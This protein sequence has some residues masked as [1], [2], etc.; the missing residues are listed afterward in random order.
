MGD[1]KRS[2]HIRCL[3]HS[4]L[5][6]FTWSYI[7]KK[8]YQRRDFLL[9]FSATCV[10]GFEWGQWWHSFHFVRGIISLW[11]LCPHCV[12]P[13]FFS[14]YPFSQITCHTAGTFPLPITSVILHHTLF[15]FQVFISLIPQIFHV[16]GGWFLTWLC[17]WCETLQWS[18]LFSWSDD[19]DGNL[20]SLC[21]M[22]RA[23]MVLLLWC[24]VKIHNQ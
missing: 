11:R 13:L 10:T 20:I 18:F 16:T 22:A 7:G 2:P 8:M 5:F 17:R 23:F 4:L 19:L 12:D 24:R 21:A 6:A 9:Q 1:T 15:I 3:N 14:L